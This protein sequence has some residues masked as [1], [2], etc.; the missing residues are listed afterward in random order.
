MSRDICEKVRL[1]NKSLGIQRYGYMI[2]TIR[3][4]LDNNLPALP[5]PVGS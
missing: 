5:I 4:S 3:Q 2:C 1:I